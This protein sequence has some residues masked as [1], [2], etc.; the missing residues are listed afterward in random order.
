MPG[1]HPL[2]ELRQALLS[3]PLHDQGPAV[4]NQAQRLPLRK[5]LGARVQHHCL[6]GGTDSVGLPTELLEHGSTAQ[7]IPHQTEGVGNLL[8]AGQRGATP[9]SRPIR[10]AQEPESPDVT[11]K[12]RHAH[13]D[14]GEEGVIAM[15]LGVVERQGLFQVHMRHGNLSQE[16]QRRAQHAVCCQLGWPAPGAPVRWGRCLVLWGDTGMVR[17]GAGG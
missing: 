10:I 15:L 8:G 3:L 16:E 7:G 12:G 5:S 14:A 13:I 2:A 11:A 1:V 17:G 4:H 6:G 9:G